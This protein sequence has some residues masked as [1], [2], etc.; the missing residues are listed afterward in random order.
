MVDLTDRQLRSVLDE[1]C[2]A[3]GL[4]S[5]DARLVHHYSNAVF[6]LPTESAVARL[7]TG[8]RTADAVT[9]SQTAVAWLTGEMRFGASAPLPGVA[10]VVMDGHLIV[11]FWRYY[12]QPGPGSVRPFKAG[13]LGR[14]LAGLHA[15]PD[16]PMSLPRW[17][18]LGSLRS[19]LLPEQTYEGLDAAEK[20]WLLAHMRDVS[21]AVMERDWPLGTGLIHGDAWAGN[22]LWDTTTSPDQVILGDWDS[23][24]I[25][26]REIDLIPTWHAAV[27]YAKPSAWVDEFIDAYGY[28]LAGSDRI[29]L[30]MQMRDLVQL[31]G[32]L[33]RAARSPVHHRALRQR[34]EAIRDGERSMTW[35]AL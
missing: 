2:A 11:S 22:L 20:S 17:Q 28:D 8:P 1:A 9:T 29:D 13:D 25:G 31:T 34:F 14:L 15:L 3:Q 21:D 12:P 4:V 24:S 27:R 26:P 33:R 19:A 7:T 30:L 23:V 18:P 6:V 16:P 5:G 35:A 10:P 32:P